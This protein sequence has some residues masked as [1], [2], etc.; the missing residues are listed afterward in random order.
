M[1]WLKKFKCTSVVALVCLATPT[2]SFADESLVKSY[3]EISDALT[4]G[5]IDEI[6]RLLKPKAD[7]GERDAQTI[8][9]MAYLERDGPRGNPK[10]AVKWFKLAAHQGQ[11]ISQFNLGTMYLDGIGVAKSEMEAAKYLEMAA[12]QGLPEAQFILGNLLSPASFEDNPRVTLGYTTIE[13][14][15]TNVQKNAQDS[16]RWYML[17]AEQGVAEAQ[18]NLALAYA[19]GIGVPKNSGNALK[20][21]RLAAKQGLALAQYNLSGRYF[22]GEG[23][24]RDLTKSYMWMVLSATSGKSASLQDRDL[25]ADELTSVQ[26][27]KAEAAAAFCIQT[28]FADCE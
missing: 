21:Y 6:L 25:I 4:V 24:Q 9:A 17:A 15:P 13:Q 28:K 23:V 18:F 22:R 20:Y 10:E 27:E 11:K 16:V 14:D 2:A 5:D 19:D 1:N 7:A 3:P 8:I 26:I 12:L